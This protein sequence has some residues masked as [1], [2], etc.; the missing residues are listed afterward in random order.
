MIKEDDILLWR[1][2]YGLLIFDLV[3]IIFAPKVI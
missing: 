2:I 3:L 1:I